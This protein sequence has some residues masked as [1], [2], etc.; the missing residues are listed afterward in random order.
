[1]TREDVS[2][3]TFRFMD[4][5]R[6]SVGMAPSVLVGRVSYTGDLGYELW[7]DATYQV[8]LLDTLMSAG[9]PL[10]LRLFGSRALN[11]LRLEKGARLHG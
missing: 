7:C 11:S 1:V 8:H 9:E 2:A 6:M 3:E 10:G 5:R 4:V